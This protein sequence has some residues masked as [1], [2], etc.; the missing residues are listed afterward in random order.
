[1]QTMN[2]IGYRDLTK[3]VSANLGALR[4]DLLDVIRPRSP[5]FAGC[6]RFDPHLLASRLFS[7][8]Y[9]E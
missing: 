9:R 1:M 3:A 4:K 8:R 7:T 6:G 2:S 5:D